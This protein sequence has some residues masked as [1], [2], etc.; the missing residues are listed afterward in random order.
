MKI[1]FSNDD[2]VHAK[3]IHVL[4]QAFARA[5]EWAIVAPE[6]ERST[7]GHSLTLHKPLRLHK[8]HKHIYS[9]SGGPADCIYL[10]VHEVMKKDPDIVIS[11]INRGANLGQ[12]VFYSGTV[13]A[14][15]EASNMGY[16]AMAVSLSLDR[17]KKGKPEH[18]ETAARCAREVLDMV[19]KIW[20]NGNVKKGLKRWPS[21]MVLNVN[22]PNLPYAKI[23]G[24][25]MAQ[26]GHRVYSGKILK[27][28]DAR[29]RKYYWIGGTYQGFRDT[30][31]NS[32]CHWV[33]KGYVAITPLELDTTM[34]SVFHTLSP[35][36]EIK[37]KK[38]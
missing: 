36:F 37:K 29:G 4:A 25:R 23:K 24:F 28:T 9:V 12:D 14:A 5:H 19:L 26:Q 22:V 20:G 1:L 11:G 2:G 32:D 8:F 7:T 18:Y 15:R 21:G 31:K 35:A 6:K 27:R 38:R 16:P 10:G 13:S 17:H 33:D 30:V 3:G 34:V